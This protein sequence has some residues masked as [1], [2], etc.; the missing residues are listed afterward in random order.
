MNMKHLGQE[1]QEWNPSEANNDK[2]GRLMLKIGI[3]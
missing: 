3:L 2:V 1:E